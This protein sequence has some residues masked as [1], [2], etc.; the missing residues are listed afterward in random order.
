M[1]EHDENPERLAAVAKVRCSIASQ[2]A[3]LLHRA[4]SFGSSDIGVTAHLE[5]LEA[6]ISKLAEEH[7][8]TM[9]FCPPPQVK[10]LYPPPGQV[11]LS[12]EST[13]TPAPEETF[14]DHEFKYLQVGN[15][16]WTVLQVSW[17]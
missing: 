10:D 3:R 17:G 4:Q 16:V 8:Q 13:D 15:D 12:P 14:V 5:F 2:W 6:T 11:V 1:D 7:G 9:V